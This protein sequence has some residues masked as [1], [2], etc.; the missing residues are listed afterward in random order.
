[1][2]EM[3]HRKHRATQF[4]SLGL[5]LMLFVLAPSRLPAQA[6]PTLIGHRAPDFSRMDL[7]HKK[8]ELRS[9]RGEVVLL[10]FWATWC[11]PCL[12]EMPAFTQWQNQYGLARFQVIGISMDDAAPGVAATASKLRLNYPVVMGDEHVGAAYGGILGLPV[13]FLIDRQGRIRYRFEGIADLVQVKKD[14]EALLK[15]D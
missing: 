8:I 14:V 5:L 11:G 7:S 6:A 1:M 2:A 12:T 13:S 9:Y 15:I 10:N 4:A 3:H